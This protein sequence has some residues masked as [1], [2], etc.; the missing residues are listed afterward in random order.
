MAFGREVSHEPQTFALILTMSDALGRPIMISTPVDGGSGTINGSF[1]SASVVAGIARLH[2]WWGARILG[3]LEA[4]YTTVARKAGHAA[5][6]I[7][8]IA[9]DGVSSSKRCARRRRAA[10]LRSGAI[11]LAHQMKQNGEGRRAAA[12]T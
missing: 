11:L 1:R 8:V 7:P 3:N 4:L 2:R 10:V 6:R 5:R 9:G 12:S